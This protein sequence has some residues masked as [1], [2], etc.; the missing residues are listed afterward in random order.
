MGVM[1]DPRVPSQGSRYKAYAALLQRPS[2]RG[3]RGCGNVWTP[4][5]AECLTQLADLRP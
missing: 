2:V 4:V 5:I 3:V 1:Y